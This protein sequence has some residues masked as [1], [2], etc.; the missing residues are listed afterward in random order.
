MSKWKAPNDVLPQISTYPVHFLLDWNCVCNYLGQTCGKPP[1]LCVPNNF[2]G[3]CERRG[4]EKEHCLQRTVDIK[5]SLTYYG[6]IHTVISNGISHQRTALPSFEQHHFT[7]KQKKKY[8]IPL[9]NTSCYVNFQCSGRF[10]SW[11]T[12]LRKSARILVS[13]EALTAEPQSKWPGT[14][15]ARITLTFLSRILLTCKPYERFTEEHLWRDAVLTIVQI[16]GAS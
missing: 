1:K 2:S 16:C 15:Q 12:I 5:R 11:S 13:K 14:I 10:R 7:T 9:N 6:S 3:D 4:R 8:Q